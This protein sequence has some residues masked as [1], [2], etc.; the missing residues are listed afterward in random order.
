MERGESRQLLPENSLAH[1]SSWGQRKAFLGK[2]ILGVLE[3]QSSHF[4]CSG[5]S[6][7]G[8]P[9]GRPLCTWCVSA[10]VWGQMLSSCCAFRLTCRFSFLLYSFFHCVSQSVVFLS[11]NKSIVNMVWLS[12]LC[13]LVMNM[14][15]LKA[16]NVKTQPCH[17]AQNRLVFLR[18]FSKGSN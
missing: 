17:L 16:T 14:Q 11:I 2:N 18:H 6:L 9:A 4:P 1:A 7:P 8:L 3:T 5:S 15:F 12:A 13:W 10:P